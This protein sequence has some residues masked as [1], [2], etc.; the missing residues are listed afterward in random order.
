MNQQLKNE[1]QLMQQEDQR[2]LQELID[3]GELGTTE[4]HP[5][6]KAV[7]EKKNTRIKEIISH[8]GWPGFSLVGKE[9]SK[10]AWLVVQ[11][12]VLDTDFMGKCLP[13]LQ[14]A[15]NQGEAEGWCLAYLQDRMLTMSGKPQIYGTQHD[16]D[17]NG[18][19]HPL[20]I[21][22]PEKVET[23]RKKVGLE[24]LS[25]ATRR[26]Q[27]RHNLTVANRRENNG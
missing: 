19:A 11:H 18:I 3:S 10:A 5:R 8:Y 27:E 6:M 15:I 23:I 14:D 22:E 4:Y 9:G 16:I 1:L 13:L 12:A 25:D 24:P 17:E 2:A 21:E 7:H 26:I 20:P